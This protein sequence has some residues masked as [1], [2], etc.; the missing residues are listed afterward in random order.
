[1]ARSS[2]KIEKEINHLEKKHA[3]LKEQVSNL[4]SRTFLT[5]DEQ[6]QRA[7]L[8]KQKLRTK[9]K[10]ERVRRDSEPPPA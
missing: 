2:L 8:K 5:S 3:A 6:T 4:D 1:M 9:D 7:E 10:L